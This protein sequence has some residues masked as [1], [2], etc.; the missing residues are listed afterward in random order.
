MTVLTLEQEAVIVTF[1][2]H[3]L[4]LLDDC[5]YALQPSIPGL[6]RSSARTGVCNGTGSR[7]CPTWKATRPLGG[8]SRSTPSALGHPRST[9]SEPLSALGSRTM[10]SAEVRTEEGKLTLFVAINR[11]SKF[12]VARL[13]D[14]TTRRTA[15]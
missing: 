1:R 15:C 5:L 12:A 7:A 10:A 3:A 14:E 4:L 9:W 6:T 8:S 11:T 2:Q 13:C